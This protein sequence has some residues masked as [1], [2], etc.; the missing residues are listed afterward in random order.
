MKKAPILPVLI[1]VVVGLI[2]AL[3]SCTETRKMQGNCPTTN[4]NFFY[5]MAGA[6]RYK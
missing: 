4:K 2:L 1:C 5:D 6:K 3:T